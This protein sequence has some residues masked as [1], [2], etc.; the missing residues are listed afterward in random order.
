MSVG[1]WTT[2]QILALAPDASSAKA[3]KELASPRKWL[4]LG[5]EGQAAWG[6][7]QGS[8]AHPYQTKIDLSEPAFQCTCPSRKFPCKHAL[9]L[10]LLLDS[11]PAVFTRD[12]PP[13]WVSTWLAA[14]A[15]RAEQRSRKEERSGTVADATAQARRAAD[16]EAK[17]AA[18]LEE[19]ELWLRDLVR[20]GLAA[21]QAQ[22]LSFWETPAARMVDAQAPGLAR[23]LREMAGIPSSGEGWQERLLER[24]GRLYLLIEG[25]RRLETLP[26]DVQA[27]VRG[28]IGWSM[29]QEEL[30][31]EPG[32]HDRW[33]VLG[34]RVEEEE[35]LRV[36]R[37]W[38]WGRD[39]G[40]AAL[41]L[42]FAHS[43]QRL[44][45]SLIPGSE[46]DAD[47][48][49][50][51]GAYPLRALVKTRPPARGYP[52]PAPLASMPGYD[53]AAAASAAYAAALAHDPWLEALP[54]PLRAVVPLRHNGGW[55]ARD[56]EGQWL[57]LSSRFARGW[58]LAALSGGH[59]LALFG[60]WDGRHLLPLSVWV[61][62]R[63]CLL[64][65]G[66]T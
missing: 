34:Q 59:P 61:E 39:S 66:E 58:H 21:A 5:Q 45:V 23:L 49:F 1:T 29:S 60:E 8:G 2:E 14:R 7:C 31:A 30:L 41:I 43:S 64:T 28:R 63:F 51:P 3:G 35:R 65:S 19:L 55:V 32:V 62:G 6:E 48:V 17:V 33:R 56:A 12:S 10:F 27:D 42:Q 47:L 13:E 53:T 36:Q 18:G 46:V 16:R 24:L 40:R 4:T 50:Y 44:D 37:T 25:F 11:Q 57:P 20:R 22:P 52:A 54:L 26:P 38:L 15:Q 9:G